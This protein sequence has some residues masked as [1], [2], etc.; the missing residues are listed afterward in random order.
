MHAGRVV[1]GA[2][3]RQHDAVGKHDSVAQHDAIAKHNSIRE[4]DAVS[5]KNPAAA[6]RRAV[7]LHQVV[8]QGQRAFPHV[9][10]QTLR[11][12]TF[13]HAVAK[14]ITFGVTL[15]ILIQ[16]ILACDRGLIEK[17]WCSAPTERS[18]SILAPTPEKRAIAEVKQVVPEILSAP[19]LL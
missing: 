1:A 5:A 3:V 17:H 13:D 14:H 7:A 15:L 19:L 8:S 2:G 11:S 18:L 12:R 10:V 4:H 9:R 6:K 16:Q